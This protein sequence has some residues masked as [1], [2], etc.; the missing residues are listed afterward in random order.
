VKFSRRAGG[1]VEFSV[2]A[3]E[4]LR[5]YRQ[6]VPSACE[7]GGIL[8]GRVIL[9]SFDVVIDEVTTPTRLDRRYSER[10]RGQAAHPGV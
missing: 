5:S 3:V 8:L 7:A 2:A 6:L 1:H 9:E 10:C 4:I